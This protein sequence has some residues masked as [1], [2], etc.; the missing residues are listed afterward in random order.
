MVSRVVKKFVSF[1]IKG[2][3]LLAFVIL[4]LAI[5]FVMVHVGFFLWVPWCLTTKAIVLLLLGLVYIGVALVVIFNI[6]S[7]KAW[8][9]G[10]QA[11]KLFKDATRNS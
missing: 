7:E 2:S 1:L 5:G 6:C 10:S 11:N 9:E 4:L 8:L 3:I